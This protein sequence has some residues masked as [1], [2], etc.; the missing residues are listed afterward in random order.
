[1]EAAAV[2]A[3]RGGNVRF[4]ALD[5][6]HAPI[7]REL[8]EAFAR[9]LDS[10]AFTLGVEV[11]RFES[12]FAEYSQARHCVGVASG[13]AALSLMLEA[14]G[15][16]RGDDVI[17]PAHTFIA[18]ALAQPRPAGERRARPARPQ[19]A[20]APPTSGAVT[21]EAAAPRSVERRTARPFGAV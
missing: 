14:Y 10:S 21:R 9:L 16:G 7:E 13:T 5:F 18:S 20:L 11:E 15:I 8:K 3:E 1:M 12:E 2:A 19:R 6:Q 17:V 4:V